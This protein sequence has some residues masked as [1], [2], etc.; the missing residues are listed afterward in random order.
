MTMT[1]TERISLCRFLEKIEEQEAYCAALAGGEEMISF[2]CFML[3][4][5]V[6]GKLAAVACRAAWGITKIAVCFVFVPLFLMILLVAGLVYIVFPIL[7]IVGI[8]GFVS[9]R[10]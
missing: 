1:I 4:L 5:A 6:F 3:M 2:L 8:I 7:I 10:V 9:S